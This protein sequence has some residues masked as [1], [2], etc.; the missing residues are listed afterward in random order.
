MVRPAHHVTPTIG[1]VVELLRS[2]K[3]KKERLEVL[4]DNTSEALKTV[5]RVNFDPAQRFSL[6]TGSV[7]FKSSEAP[8]G[9]GPT[10][11]K[12]QYKRFYLFIEGRHRTLSQEKREHL[13]IELLENLDPQEAQLMID[14]KD[15]K[16]K[17]GVTRKLLDEIYPGM[18]PPVEKK[19]RESN[20][21]QETAEEAA[22]E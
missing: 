19:K 15:Q 5:F 8:N 20:K 22:G 6:P 2:A 1:Q 12:H 7:K 9:L 3:T 4:K 14:I 18:I 17:C 16:L 11:I 10:T 21:Q 13:F